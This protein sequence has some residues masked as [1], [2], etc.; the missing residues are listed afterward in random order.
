MGRIV[1]NDGTDEANFFIRF[2]GIERYHEY[3]SLD[4]MA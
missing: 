2:K 1:T 3:T 4:Q